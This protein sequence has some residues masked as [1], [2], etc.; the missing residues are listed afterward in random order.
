MSLLSEISKKISEFAK[1]GE[2]F[3]FVVDFLGKNA[4]I[5]TP[6]EAANNNIYYNFKGKT[7]YQVL[8]QSFKKKSFDFFPVS[9]EQYLKGFNVVQTALERGDTYLLNYTCS[10]PIQTEYSLTELYEYSKAPFKLLY[11]DKF[12]VS[13]PERFIKISKQQIETRPM[14]GTIDASVIDAEQVLLS[15]E[16]E[17]FEHNTIVDLLR[18][19]LNIVAKNVRV[20]NFR[21][22]DRIKTNRGEL[23]QVSSKIV[24]DL[25]IDYKSKMGDIIVSL[26]PA[27]SVSGAPKKKTLEVICDAENYNR[28][29][30]TGVFGYFDGK[31]L[32]VAVSIRFIEKVADNLFYKSGGGITALSDAK[33]EYNE[34][35]DKIYVPFF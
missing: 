29:F 34:M 24:G 10:T 11:K 13:S 14:K 26:L 6:K 2:E 21:Y 8:E 23:L 3:F 7:N 4:E 9:Y 12:V 25:P 32:D 19:D 22:I 18:N 16:K 20:D 27:G 15:N 28:G 35:L 30:Y 31:D 1:N 33:E 17:L 5:Y